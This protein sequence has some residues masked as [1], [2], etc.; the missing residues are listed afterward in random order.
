M[1][2]V[3]MAKEF[4]IFLFVEAGATWTYV[5]VKNHV[6]LKNRK[7]KKTWSLILLFLV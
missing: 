1:Q 4:L 7:L 5:T 6:A 2:D 3:N